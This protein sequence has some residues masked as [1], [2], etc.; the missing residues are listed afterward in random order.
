M[1]VIL[2]NAVQTRDNLP[3]ISVFIEKS[4]AKIVEADHPDTY[5]ATFSSTNGAFRIKGSHLPVLSDD[6][7][8]ATFY[9]WGN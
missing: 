2:G 1:V 9:A 3:V 6:N 4:V 5:Q 8:Q 7:N